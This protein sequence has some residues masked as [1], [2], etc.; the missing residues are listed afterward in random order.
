MLFRSRKA[1]Q[2]LEITVEFTGIGADEKGIVINSKRAEFKN[3]IGKE[4]VAVDPRYFRPTEVELLIGDASK[5]RSVL[6][7]VPEYTLDALIR[8]M[9]ISD[10]RLMQKE[11]FLKENGFNTLNYF[12]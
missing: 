11:K 3:L 2:E 8:E 5:A 4:V 7:W 10:F 6:N 1:F 9:V 12:E